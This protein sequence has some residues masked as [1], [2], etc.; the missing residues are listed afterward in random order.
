MAEMT[1]WGH[2]IQIRYFANSWGH[3]R[4]A[5]FLSKD[6]YSFKRYLWFVIFW[7]FASKIRFLIELKKFLMG[8]W[9]VQ[10][11]KCVGRSENDQKQKH[12]IISKSDQIGFKIIFETFWNLLMRFWNIILWTRLLQYFQVNWKSGLANYGVFPII[13]RPLEISF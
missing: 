3:L 9:S 4:C 8:S 10:N 12:W 5:I 6:V 1:S 7:V 2:C 13:N 11:I